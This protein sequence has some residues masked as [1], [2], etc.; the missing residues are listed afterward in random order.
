[1]AWPL[2][3]NGN[4]PT[5]QKVRLPN[6]VERYSAHHDRVGV[7]VTLTRDV[8]VWNIGG[9]L[10]SLDTSKVHEQLSDFDKLDAAV[11]FHPFDESAAFVVYLATY[12]WNYSSARLLIQEFVNNIPGSIHVVNLSNTRTTSLRET[13]DFLQGVVIISKVD[14]HCTMTTPEGNTAPCQHI[15]D[16]SNGP[17]LRDVAFVTFNIYTKLFAF[18]YYHIPWTYVSA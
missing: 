14:P 6:I 3:T 5:M 10:I 4:D 1:M 15:E 2:N 8:F 18:Q 9:S 13:F 17:R 16:D 12:N 7:V 11:L